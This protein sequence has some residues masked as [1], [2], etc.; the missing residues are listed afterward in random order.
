MS[1]SRPMGR[2]K[3][4]SN[5][6][7]SDYLTFPEYRE[8]PV[9][10]AMGAV[11]ESK[12]D[13]TSVTGRPLIQMFISVVVMLLVAVSWAMSTQFSKSAMTYKQEYFDAAY[14]MVWFSTLFMTSCYPVYLLYAVAIRRGDFEKVH[15][16][17][18]KIFGKHGFTYLGFL[19]R[20]CLFLFLWMGANYAYSRALGQKITASVASSIMSCNT[21]IICVLGWFVLKDRVRFS[22]ILSVAFA[23]GGVVVISLDKEF[24]G[25]ALGIGLAIFSTVM[26]A[27]Y[28]VLF[29]RVNGDA[30]LGQVSLFMTGLGLMNTTLNLI[31]TAALYFT[32]VE[33]IVWEY[34]PWGPLIGSA[35]LGLVFNFLINFGIA[36]LHPLI[37]SIGMLLGLP[38]SAAYDILFR[39]MTATPKFLTGASLILLSFLL[40]I[41]P[42]EE[43][44]KSCR[45]HTETDTAETEEPVRT[46][47]A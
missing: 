9:N 28:K 14:F 30:S 32:G 31:P 35:L 13:A 20:E 47:A 24:A 36:L 15:S 29:K 3:A 23:I 34:V 45:R 11:A 2:S 8:L 39:D 17:A 43:F 19:W 22:Q 25:D 6:R 44:V 40:I 26:A 10:E 1:S 12:D 7:S 16:E 5:P 46:V 4:S 21:A 27:C 42:F 33:T 41:L 18:S 37:I 38:L